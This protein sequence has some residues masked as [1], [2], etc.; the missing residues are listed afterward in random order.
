MPTHSNDR[1]ALT[2]FE[3]EHLTKINKLAKYQ[4]L[5]NTPHR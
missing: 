5:A 3:G 4:I 2:F 1:S